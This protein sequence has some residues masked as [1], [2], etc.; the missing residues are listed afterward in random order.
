MLIQTIPSKNKHTTESAMIAV[1]LEVRPMQGRKDH[2]TLAARL[3]AAL[4]HADG[5]ISEHSR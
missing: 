1:I 5:F 2:L 3:R 4:E